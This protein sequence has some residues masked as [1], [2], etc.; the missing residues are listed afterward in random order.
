M[1]G[2]QK[3]IFLFFLLNLN[4]ILYSNS[5]ISKIENK[6]IKEKIVYLEDEET[7]FTGEFIGPNIKET[8][9]NG[10][11][12]GFFQ[13]ILNFNNENLL[14]QGKYI[15]GIKHGNWI[16]KYIDGE[17]KA[18]LKYNYNKPDGRWVTFYKNNKMENHEEL[19]NGILEGK[20]LKY[21]LRGNTL[22]RLDYN[23][24]LLHGEGVFFYENGVLEMISNFKYG[25]LYGK[26]KIF[27]D[28]NINLVDGEYNQNLRVGIWKFYYMT[29]DLKTIINYKNGMRNGESII[30][31]KSG[32]ELSRI[33]YY[34][35]IE[36]GKQEMKNKKN[37]KDSI[38]KKINKVE[39][40]LIYEK[41]DKL[42]SELEEY[43]EKY[44]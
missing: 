27:S 43:N 44:N 25:K 24:G 34:N 2:W 8:Y 35:G 13:G 4:I 32:M 41:Y 31:D 26:I 10:I 16:I 28:K 19:K 30:F 22:I 39:E 29:G 5:K 11:K 38:I 33:V 37:I 12:D 15:N 6:K 17:T 40:E 36:Q 9:K 20:V 21:S 7:P 3:K 1:K 23:H 14:Y 42:L 18:I